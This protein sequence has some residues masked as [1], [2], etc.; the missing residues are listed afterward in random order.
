[1]VGSL[2]LNDGQT[3]PDPMRMNEKKEKGISKQK[4]NSNSYM[5][6]YLTLTPSGVIEKTSS[7][8]IMHV[9]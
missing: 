2:P 3:K 4:F 8:D 7:S 5:S 9:L 6:Q 1:M